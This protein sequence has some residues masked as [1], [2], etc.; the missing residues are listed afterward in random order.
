MVLPPTI[1]QPVKALAPEEGGERS[2]RAV[3]GSRLKSHAAVLV[4]RS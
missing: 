4:D 1:G 3:P 2:V